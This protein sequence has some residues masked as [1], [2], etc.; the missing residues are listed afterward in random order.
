MYEANAILEDKTFAAHMEDLSTYLENLKRRQMVSTLA[1][2]FFSWLQAVARLEGSE[3][4][5]SEQ[6]AQTW[7]SP[8][9]CSR[10]PL[11]IAERFSQSSGAELQ[12][13]RFTALSLDV[14]S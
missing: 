13:V 2:Q 12:E 5:Q 9:A 4:K 7:S 3:A 1:A 6:V 10:E 14:P 8:A 11:R